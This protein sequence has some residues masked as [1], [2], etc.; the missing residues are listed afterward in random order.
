MDKFVE[1]FQIEPGA[2]IAMVA[3]TGGIT[4]SVIS[5][6][7][8]AVVQVSRTGTRERSRRELAAYV[9]EGTITPEVAERM[10][11]A[12]RKPS[13]NAKKGCC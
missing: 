10:L 6:I 9:A 12:G 13:S 7:A 2:I 3:I 4:L 1:M 5:V 8:N 11:E